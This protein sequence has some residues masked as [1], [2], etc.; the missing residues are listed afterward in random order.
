MAKVLANNVCIHTA[1]NYYKCNIHS[2][3]SFVLVSPTPECQ[4]LKLLNAT[5]CSAASCKYLSAI[6][7]NEAEETSKTTKQYVCKF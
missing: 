7:K 2:H 4:A 6:A 1:E 5:L 3:F